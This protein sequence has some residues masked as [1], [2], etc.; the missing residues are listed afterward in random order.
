MAIYKGSAVIY[1]SFFKVNRLKAVNGDE[2]HV[3]KGST[4]SFN[5]SA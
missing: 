4:H 3:T 5:Y 1:E 2:P